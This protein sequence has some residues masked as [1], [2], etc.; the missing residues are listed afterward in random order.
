MASLG[1]RLGVGLKAR[2]GLLPAQDE[3]PA[4]KFQGLISIRG[5]RSA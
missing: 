4:S 3:A 2:L 1:D 5:G